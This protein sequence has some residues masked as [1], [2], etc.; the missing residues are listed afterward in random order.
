MYKMTK[1]L[2]RKGHTEITFVGDQPELWGVDAQRLKGHKA[3]LAEAGIAWD[4]RRY[5][6]IFR[7][8]SLHI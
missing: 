6:C 5:F 8:A 3:A 2:I 7:N 4:E 1:H